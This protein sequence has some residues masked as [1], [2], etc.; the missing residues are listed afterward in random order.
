[1]SGCAD[2]KALLKTNPDDAIKRQAD[3]ALLALGAS[4]KNVPTLRIDVTAASI[5]DVQQSAQTTFH[6]TARHSE[7]DI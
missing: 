7:V 6:G 4:T 3:G 1:V 5:N 2:L